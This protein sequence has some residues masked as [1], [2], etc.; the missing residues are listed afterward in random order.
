MKFGAFTF[1][2]IQ[3]RELIKFM[4]SDIKPEDVVSISTDTSSSRIDLDKRDMS[5]V[6]KPGQHVQRTDFQEYVERLDKNNQKIFKEIFEVI[7]DTK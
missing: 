3:G 5:P 4:E 6:F 1:F 2:I 7:N